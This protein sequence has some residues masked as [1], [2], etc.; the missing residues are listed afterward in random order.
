MLDKF[1]K[2]ARTL[3]AGDVLAGVSV[4]TVLIPQSLAYAEL[5]GLPP[6]LGLYA[7]ALPPLAAALFASSPYLQTG[8][9]AL[10]S[11]LTFGILST[12]VVPDS[13]ALPGLAA[14][15]AL[16]VGVVRLLLGLFR[17]RTLAYLLSQPVMTGFTTA[18]ALLILGS[19]LPAALG[20]TPPP[21]HPLYR[22]GWLLVQPWLWQP[23]ALVFS[24]L[25]FMLI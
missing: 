9:V 21:G 23:E 25:T 11:L 6:Q 24:V 18:A 20:V 16:M 2:T 7:A 8:H 1:V 10:T 17:L 22:V 13:V 3:L 19:Q 5:A 12:L 14:L 4:A 15:L